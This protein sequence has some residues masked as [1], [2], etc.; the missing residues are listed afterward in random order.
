MGLLEK[1]NSLPG[2]KGNAGVIFW[3]TVLFM[4]IRPSPSLQKCLALH[5]GVE[6]L[7]LLRRS[8]FLKC[9]SI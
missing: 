2:C 5:W 6:E 7:L 1:D 3:G 8:M 9:K 4:M